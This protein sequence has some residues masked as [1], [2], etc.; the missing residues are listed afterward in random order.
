MTETSIDDV[1]ANDG[2]QLAAQCPPKSGSVR[3]RPYT[4]TGIRRIYVIEHGRGRFVPVCRS[5]S[6]PRKQPT[7]QLRM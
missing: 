3:R 6:V 4:D 5:C 7:W 1:L 2:C